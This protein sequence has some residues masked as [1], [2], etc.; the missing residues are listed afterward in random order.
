MRRVVVVLMLSALTL[1]ALAA[2]GMV[3][4]ESA[5]SVSKTSE[6][7]VAA[8]ERAGMTVMA[9]V[10]HADNAQS[11]GK[12]L[13]P[14]QLV[15]FGN[16]RVGTPLMRCSQ[17]AAIDLPQKALIW[18]DAE[19]DVWLGYNSPDYLQ[20]RHAITGCDDTLARIEQALAKF[21]RAAAGD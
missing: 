12:S 1:P 11:V 9:Q 10:D 2:D 4:V 14:T 5:Y 8:L 17:T 7:L 21:A 19:S 15:I 20:A 16:P 18:E 3:R 13:R 6:R